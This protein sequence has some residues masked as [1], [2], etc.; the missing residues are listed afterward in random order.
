MVRGL[1]SSDV[2]ISSKPGWLIKSYWD[3]AMGRFLCLAFSSL[4]LLHVSYS[5]SSKY[6]FPTSCALSLV[7]PSGEVID[8]FHSALHFCVYLISL[9]LVKFSFGGT[10]AVLP[11]VP[12]ITFTCMVF[13]SLVFKGNGFLL[14]DG[15]N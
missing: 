3:F 2:K 5:W 1:H 15:P 6:S 7:L 8:F 10:F 4:S 13:T 9:F 12:M 14:F 11:I